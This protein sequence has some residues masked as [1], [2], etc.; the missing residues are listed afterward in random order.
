MVSL[1]AETDGTASEPAEV[2]LKWKGQAVAPEVKPKLYAVLVGVS[3]YAD[4]SIPALKWAA[5]DARDLADTLKKQEGLLY[6]KVTIRLLVDEQATSSAVIDELDWISRA[7][8]Q[9]DRV[10]VF[11]AGHGVTDERSEY[12]FLP[13][14]AEIDRSTGLVVP[15]RS[16]AVKRS[17]IVASLRETQGHALFLFDTCHAAAATSRVALRSV[18]PNLVPFINELRS[19]ENGV[20][21]LSSSEGRELSQERDDWKHG[22]FTKALLEGV[23]GSADFNHDSVVTFSELNSYVGDRVKELTANRQHPVLHAIHPSR[24]LALAAVKK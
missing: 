22:A 7:G 3:K 2:K 8:S 12:Y 23:D 14:N 13:T 6:D 17:D 10:I 16:T 15:R 9:G 18:G 1:I 20:L 19:A 11:L 5:Q 4:E 21:V 24:D